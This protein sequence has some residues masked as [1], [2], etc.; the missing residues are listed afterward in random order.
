VGFWFEKQK[1]SEGL[2]G[3]RVIRTM[4]RISSKLLITYQLF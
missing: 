4:T 3:N 2:S 1:S